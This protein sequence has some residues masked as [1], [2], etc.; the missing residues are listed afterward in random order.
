M[1]REGTLQSIEL[2]AREVYLETAA[3]MA[4]VDG[5]VRT[6]MLSLRDTPHAYGRR[7][8]YMGPRMIMAA[9][10]ALMAELKIYY[11]RR[12]PKRSLWEFNWATESALAGSNVALRHGSK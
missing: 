2:A 6:A 3:F 4:A 11:K 9:T 7:R 12:Y 1:K 5:D 8:T 10:K